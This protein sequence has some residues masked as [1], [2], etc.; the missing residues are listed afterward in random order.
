MHV[1]KL[2][3]FRKHNKRY[4]VCIQCYFEDTLLGLLYRLYFSCNLYS[5]LLVFLCLEN[6]LKFFL[7][8]QG[9]DWSSLKMIESNGKRKYACPICC[10]LLS[11]YFKAKEHVENMHLYSKPRCSCGK[12]FSWKADLANHLKKTGHAPPQ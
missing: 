6:V 2:Y 3:A 9:F 1:H 5:Y 7:I 4:H 12:E 10:K 11:S 8:F